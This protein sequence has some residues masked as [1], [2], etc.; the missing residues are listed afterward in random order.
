MLPL[1]DALDAARICAYLLFIIMVTLALLG[2]NWQVEH[3][4]IAV[5]PIY[6]LLEVTV[7]GAAD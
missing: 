5:E 2:W 7:G 1:D 6:S 3:V 4:T